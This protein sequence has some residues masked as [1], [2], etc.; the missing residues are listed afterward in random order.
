MKKQRVYSPDV[1]EPAA[2][3]WSNALRVGPQLFISG[4][5]ARGK[6]LDEIT[7]DDEYQ[8]AMAVFS[9]IQ[10]LVQAA[11]GEMND[12]VK[13][14][15]YVTRIQHNTAVWQARR[16][17]FSGDFPACTLVEV[18]ALARPDILLEIE[19]TAFIGCAA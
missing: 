10:H 19:A 15:I 16:E 2:G 8:Q 5:T 4:L 12:I 17:F 3:L 9:K 1:T 11:G 13:M 6:N 14:T 18:S 7:G